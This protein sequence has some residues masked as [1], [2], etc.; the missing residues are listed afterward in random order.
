[1]NSTIRQ[2]SFFITCMLLLIFS[3]VQLTEL[4][5]SHAEENHCAQSLTIKKYNGSAAVAKYIAKCKF[6]KDLAHKQLHHFYTAVPSSVVIL[7]SFPIKRQHG[8]AQKLFETA[9]HCWT[10]KGPPSSYSIF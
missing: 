4:L 1:M 8:A 9:I 6:C 2:F 10:N 5:H 7:K 3:T